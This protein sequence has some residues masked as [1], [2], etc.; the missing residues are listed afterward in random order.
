MPNWKKVIVSGSAAEIT[1]LKSTGLS[2]QASEQTSLMINSSNVVGTRELGA[3]AFN[4]TTIPTNNNQLTNGAGYVTTDTT[5]T[6]GNGG[7][8]EINFTTA[9]N[10][11]LD[12][13]EPEAKDD[14]T[15]AEILSE[16]KSVD[17]NGTAGINAGTCDGM[18]I[19]PAATRNSAA[20]KVVTTQATGYVEFGWINTTSGNT[21][22][23]I[24]D[25][26]VNTNDGYIRKATTAQFKSNLGITDTTYTADGNYGMTLS[27]T[28]FRLEDDRRRNSSA[29]DIYTGNT[30]DFT[31]YDN[32]V[33]I[34]WYTA[35]AEDMRLLDNGTLHVD[36]DIIA[37][38][39]TISDER[40]KDN[41]TTIEN[42]L[43]KIKALRGVEYD[44][45]NGSRKGKHDLGF[46][47]QEV[48]T[49]IPDIVHE[50]TMPLMDGD[51]DT[52]YKTVDY[53]KVTA[54]LIEGMK[55]QQTQIDSLKSE[56]TDL[57][58]R[59]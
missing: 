17:V 41:I 23:T 34:R 44:W 20:N 39:T 58:R 51:E 32:D 42:P 1:T 33:G 8:T 5:Y 40:L 21:T 24:T 31:W 14:Q 19:H 12:G 7:L 4:S 13:I 55:E 16:L 56:L 30:H 38:S 28:T 57:Q 10:S 27:G 54:L 26:Y 25:V 15:A 52:V 35:G 2:A 50:H 36:G 18:E 37:F 6:V 47:A 45:N 29:V 11:K 9:L 22:N 48:E 59:V 46:I 43:D 3:N 53:E 49:V